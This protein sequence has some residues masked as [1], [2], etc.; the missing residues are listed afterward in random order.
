MN[1][2]PNDNPNSQYL[3][4]RCGH[5]ESEHPVYK[6]CTGFAISQNV[7]LIT[8]ELNKKIICVYLNGERIA[9]R[10]PAPL[11]G[12]VWREIVISKDSILEAIGVVK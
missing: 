2:N 4:A 3:C 8:V 9:G 6:K 5:P 12:S 7:T 10:N 1:K 11:E